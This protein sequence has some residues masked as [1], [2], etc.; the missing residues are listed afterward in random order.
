[1]FG[2]RGASGVPLRSAGVFVLKDA[3]RRDPAAGIT[4]LLRAA[5]A[6]TEPE[7]RFKLT[8]A[9][10]PVRDPFRDGGE[11]LRDFRLAAALGQVGPAPTDLIVIEAA[12][13]AQSADLQ[14]TVIKIR[15]AR[16]SAAFAGLMA[17]AL[18]GLCAVSHPLSA[19]DTAVTAL[20]FSAHALAAAANIDPDRAMDAASTRL[21][22]RLYARCN[23][24]NDRDPVDQEVRVLGAWAAAWTGLATADTARIDAARAALDAI[25]HDAGAD[26]TPRERAQ[27]HCNLAIVGLALGGTAE[28]PRRLS[29]ALAAARTAR[30]MIAVEVEPATRMDLNGLIGEIA[31]VLGERRGDRRLL[32]E[33]EAALVAA[34]GAGTKSSAEARWRDL[35]KRAKSGASGRG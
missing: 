21:V 14:S 29:E 7:L 20:A 30:D 18:E 10:R 28:G 22:E 12:S 16:T 33:A 3:G 6:L 25:A 31:I 4:E 26:L 27:I 34:L 13:A 17:P 19:R 2:V 23:G 32:L 5:L 35:L 15:P 24:A 11:G 8:E 9:A 1:M